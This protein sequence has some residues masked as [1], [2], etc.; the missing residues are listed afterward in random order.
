MHFLTKGMRV[1]VTHP[2]LTGSFKFVRA[3]PEGIIVRANGQLVVVGHG[4][5]ILNNGGK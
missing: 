2:N 1:K 4:Y 3:I 5:Y